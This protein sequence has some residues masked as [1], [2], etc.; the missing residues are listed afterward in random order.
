MIGSV[1]T[2]LANSEEDVRQWIAAD[3]YTKS[4]VWNVEKATILPVSVT[5]SHYAVYFGAWVGMD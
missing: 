3:I 5:W 4:G 1:M 2:L